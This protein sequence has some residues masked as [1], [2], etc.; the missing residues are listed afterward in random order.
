MLSEALRLIR[1]FHDLNQSE[2]AK[3]IEISKSYLSEIEGGKKEPSL[4]LIKKYSSKFNIPVSSIMFF[5]ENLE[6]EDSISKQARKAKG[7][8]ANKIINFLLLIESKTEENE[9]KQ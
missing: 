1:V 2:L 9:K 6:A 8:I 7:V 3:Q 5:A 4:E